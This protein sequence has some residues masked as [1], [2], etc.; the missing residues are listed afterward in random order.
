[1]DEPARPPMDAATQPAD[2]S[3]LVSR[4]SAWLRDEEARARRVPV[5]TL[6]SETTALTP[7]AC[8]ALKYRPNL[9]G[10]PMVRRM[11][12]NTVENVGRAIAQS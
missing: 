7:L 9:L 5:L 3:A 6:G 12:L 1:M 10:Q 11:V 2:D 8:K 4:Q